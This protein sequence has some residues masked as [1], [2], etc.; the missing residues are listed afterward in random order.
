MN[1]DLYK[2]K[3]MYEKSK[4]VAQTKVKIIV[5]IVILSVGKRQINSIAL[6]FRGLLRYNITIETKE[7][8]KKLLLFCFS[9]KLSKCNASTLKHSFS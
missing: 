8:F 9:L 7:L 2:M 4:N 3:Y 6:E 1:G 5:Q